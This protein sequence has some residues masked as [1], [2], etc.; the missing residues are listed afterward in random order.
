MFNPKNDLK[1]IKAIKG[2]LRLRGFIFDTILADLMSKSS[3]FR[4]SI[5][6]LM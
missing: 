2:F 5:N 3:F 6:F 4:F 1:R